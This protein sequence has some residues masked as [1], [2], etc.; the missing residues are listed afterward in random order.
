MRRGHRKIRMIVL[1]LCFSNLIFFAGCRE[2]KT[3]SGKPAEEVY[4]LGDREIQIDLSED[5]TCTEQDENEV[6]LSGNTGEIKL[7]YLEGEGIS[8]E[9]FPESE[10]D[11]AALYEEVI[12]DH[13]YQIEEF[14]SYED[15]GLYYATIR[16][17]LEGEVKYLI[18]SGTFGPEYG[19]R[20]SAFLNTGNRETAQEIQNAVYNVKVF[21]D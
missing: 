6:I 2:N 12:G 11:C 13:S 5:F 9:Y 21:K 8:S 4:E 1:F 19:C 3:V 15:E 14:H 18:T 20:I 10:Q 7:E 16:Y 17:D